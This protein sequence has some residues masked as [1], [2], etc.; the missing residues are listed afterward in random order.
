MIALPSLHLPLPAQ[1][2]ARAARQPAAWAVHAPGGSWCWREL[3]ER[4][5]AATERLR[6][7]GVNPGDRLVIL[8]ENS[9][10][11]VVLILAVRALRAWPAAMGPTGKLLK[12]ELAP[13]ADVT[14]RLSETTA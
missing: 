5:A 11:T 6:V 10:S 7:L 8:S 2:A 12:C 14:A 3:A 13:R 9:A 1:L 4:V